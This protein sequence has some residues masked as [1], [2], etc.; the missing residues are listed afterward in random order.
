MFPF[1]IRVLHNRFVGF[2]PLVSMCPTEHLASFL[3]FSIILSWLIDCNL[4]LGYKV[5]SLYCSTKLE[6]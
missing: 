1:F 3:L 6:L 4:T 2:L 5:Q